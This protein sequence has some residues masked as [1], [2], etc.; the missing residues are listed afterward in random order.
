[1]SD[2]LPERGSLSERRLPLF[3]D[4]TT[5]E[6]GDLVIAG[7]SLEDLAREY[8]TPLYLYDRLTLDA[9]VEAYRGALARY[10]PGE[11]SLTYAGKA[12]LCTALAQWAGQQGLMVDC[13]GVSEMLMAAAGGLGRKQI[14]VHGVN[15]STVDLQMALA[16]AGKLVI[17][18]LAELERLADLYQTKTD[19]FPELWLRLRPGA[20]PNTHSYLQTGQEVSKF[21]MHA[22]EVLKAA[23]ICQQNDLPLTGL[24]FHLGSQM[25][26]ATPIA[27]ALETALSMMAAIRD[28]TGIELKEICPG[29]GLGVAYHKD[30][31]PHP[32]I[33]AA[34]RMLAEKLVAGCQQ[35]HLP[36][37][38]LVLEPG[39]SIVARAGV[40]LYRVG[41]VKQAGERRWLILDGGLADN[42]RPALYKARYSCLPV[43]EVERVLSGAAWLGGPYCETGDVLI[44]AIALPDIQPGEVMA[45]PVSGAYQLSMASNYNGAC[46]PAVLWLENG[47]A[48]LIQEREQPEHLLWRD[49]RIPSL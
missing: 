41:A 10:Y 18:H 38:Q 1:M 27:A 11:S 5:L 49:R 16:Q 4:G 39:R 30:D 7:C 3:P 9:A 26:D 8:G 14:L 45:V 12:Y 24:H 46:R 48:H 34:V 19:P 44:E 31:L 17:D 29:G 28:A 47:T 33:D 40:C 36:L 22:V 35:H 2:F 43:T 21:G 42:P 13:T 25:R 37:P 15:K 20:A 32:D 6:H 23:E